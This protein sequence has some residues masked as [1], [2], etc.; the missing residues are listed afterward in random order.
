[1]KSSIKNF[2]STLGAFLVPLISTLVLVILLYLPRGD[3]Y[4][5]FLRQAPFYAG[6]YFWQSQRPDAFN[7]I[8]AFILGIFAD[9]MG[10]VLLGINILSFLLLYLVSNYLSERFNIKKFSYSWLLFSVAL[11]VT[12]LFKGMIISIFFRQLLPLNIL[13]IEFLLTLSVYPLLARAYIWVERRFI[14]LEERYEKVQ[15]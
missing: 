13:G 8:S 15:S 9:V 5:N 2:L 1:M 14:H 6:I 7:F 4:W 10:G 3:S 12:M 11:L